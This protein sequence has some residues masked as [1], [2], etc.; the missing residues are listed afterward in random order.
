METHE[1]LRQRI[2]ALTTPIVLD[3]RTS[4]LT[5]SSARATLDLLQDLV[6]TGS[7][8][9]I[10]TRVDGTEGVRIAIAAQGRRGRVSF[11]GT[12]SGYEL[13]GLVS[14]IES[15]ADIGPPLPENLREV[16]SQIDRPLAAD[17][18]VAPT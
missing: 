4:D 18:Y 16:A 12:P 1:R 8:V 9:T 7:R 3:V 13:E 17:L 5:Q 10:D 15:A 11:W 6:G 2:A 14:A